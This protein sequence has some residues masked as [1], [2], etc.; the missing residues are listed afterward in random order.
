MGRLFPV[1][2]LSEIL[3][4]IFGL[5]AKLYG[6]E[7]L[8]TLTGAT[9]H[10]DLATVMQFWEDP[11]LTRS[12]DTLRPELSLHSG[13]QP[14]AKVFNPGFS[15]SLW[16]GGVRILNS[17]AQA[18]ELDLVSTYANLDEIDIFLL[19]A[20]GR[21]MQHVEMGDRVLPVATDVRFRLPH[22]ALRFPSGASELWVRTKTSGPMLF[23]FQLLDHEV[24]L[25]ATLRDYTFIV[26][27][28]IVLSG[29]MLSAGIAFYFMRQPILLNFAFFIA[30][31]IAQAL[32]YS[33]LFQHLMA[34]TRWLM[35][36]GYVLAGGLSGL[37]SFLFNQRFL[38]LREQSP[39]L[40][41]LHKIAMAGACFCMI[42]TFVSFSDATRF[43]IA[44]AI[45]TSLVA[46]GTGIRL[47]F[48]AQHEAYYFLFGWSFVSILNLLRMQMLAGRIDPSF[49]VEW[50]TLLGAGFLSLILAIGLIDQLVQ[51]HR[52]MQQAQNLAETAKIIEGHASSRLSAR[53]AHHLNNPMNVLHLASGELRS[54]GSQLKHLVDRI[55]LEAAAED[56]EAKWVHQE[57]GAH[58]QRLETNSDLVASAIQRASEMVTEIRTLSGIDGGSCAEIDWGTV[59]QR[60]RN[61][62]EETKLF[63]PSNSCEFKMATFADL[64]PVVGNTLIMSHVLESLI[65][66]IKDWAQGPLHIQAHENVQGNDERIAIV[67]SFT[68]LA[69]VPEVTRE[70]LQIRFA[71]LLAPSVA[72]VTMESRDQTLE[73]HIDLLRPKAARQVPIMAQSA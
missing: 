54:E 60:L 39:R 52:Q 37:S 68:E 49:L 50:G 51:Q 29:V 62:L 42:A 45:L 53:A 5:G 43:A 67:F 31:L 70:A 12:L 63:H 30:S 3:T 4:V 23:S 34:D 20:S 44:L 6:Q 32:A 64:S 26:G 35:N 57:F 22:V 36:E 47:C 38:R 17:D 19:D 41:L 7:R 72:F 1:L 73:L 55:F 66:E 14:S 56:P 71:A 65:L 8:L 58:L 15:H 10:I 11:T 48:K 18:L 16:W 33:G 9:Q 40:N 61:A 13:L 46:L 28:L 24:F 21:I 25:A 27:M 59:Q 69:Q 2:M